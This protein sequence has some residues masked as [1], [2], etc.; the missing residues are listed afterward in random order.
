MAKIASGFRVRPV[1]VPNVRIEELAFPE[2]DEAIRRR[3]RGLILGFAWSEALKVQFRRPTAVLQPR[4][5]LSLP[6]PT[7]VRVFLRELLSGFLGPR[8]PAGG[9][10]KA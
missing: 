9:L 10:P 3:H 4:R 7:A 5:R 2:I 1:R 6:G 8:V